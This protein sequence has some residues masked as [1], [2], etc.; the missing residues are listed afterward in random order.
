[1]VQACAPGAGLAAYNIAVSVR[2]QR[3]KIFAFNAT[4]DQERAAVGDRIRT[5]SFSKPSRASGTPIC[6][7]R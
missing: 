5:I 4:R 6:S 2:E 7:R 1:M 3:R